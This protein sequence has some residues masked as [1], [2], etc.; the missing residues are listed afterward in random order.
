MRA[1]CPQGTLRANPR[2][3]PRCFFCE[4]LVR[5]RRTPWERHRQVRGTV[6]ATGAPGGSAIGVEQQLRNSGVVQ[7]VLDLALR[8]TGGTDQEHNLHG[9]TEMVVKRREQAHRTLVTPLLTTPSRAEPHLIPNE[10]Q[11]T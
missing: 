11:A 6:H 2:H 3:R 8:L 4:M 5:R 10:A 7:L 1:L 9:A